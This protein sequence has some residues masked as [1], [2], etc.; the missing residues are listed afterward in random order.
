MGITTPTANGDNS[1]QRKDGG[2][3]DTNNNPADFVGPKTGSLQNLT[4][5]GG[6][7]P[8]ITKIHTVQGPGAGR[9]SRG[10]PSPWRA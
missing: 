8:E 9:P 6:N 3:Q 1:F 10:G 2:R 5:E 4:G 7:G